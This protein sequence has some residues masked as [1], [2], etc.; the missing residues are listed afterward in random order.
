MSKR[1]TQTQH[2]IAQLY[3]DHD[4]LSKAGQATL[5]DLAKLWGVPTDED[6]INGHS[7]D[8]PSDVEP[9]DG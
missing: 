6:L 7:G 5:D 2:L 1:S 3:W 8:L 9:K 4:R